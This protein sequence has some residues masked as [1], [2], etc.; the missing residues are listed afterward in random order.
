MSGYY[1]I[2][3]Q[4]V[5]L[6]ATGYE[7][8]GFS[9]CSLIPTNTPTTTPTNT[10]TVTPSST[11]GDKWLVSDCCSASPDIILI[12]P[13]GTIAGQRVVYNNNCWTTVSTSVGS[14]VGAGVTFVGTNSCAACIA[15]Y[16]C[17]S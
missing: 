2:S 3:G 1:S 10:P 6:L 8:L 11:G 5:Q 16:P 17:S 12:L 9:L 4:V 15:V 14:P 7:T 13:P